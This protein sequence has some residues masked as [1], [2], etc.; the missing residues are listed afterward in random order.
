MEGFSAEE[1]GESRSQDD[2]CSVLNDSN[3]RV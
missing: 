2:V 1:R 3:D